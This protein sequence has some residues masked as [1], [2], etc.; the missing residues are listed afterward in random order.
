MYDQLSLDCSTANDLAPSLE[1]TETKE[2]GEVR[3]SPGFQA[4]QLSV[5]RRGM[6]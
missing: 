5:E 6:S 2:I 1:T 4:K 3:R